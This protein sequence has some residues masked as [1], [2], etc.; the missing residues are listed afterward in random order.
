MPGIDAAGVAVVPS[1]ADGISSYSL[2][3]V[4]AHR[5]LENRER[6]FWFGLLLTGY[7]SFGFPFLHAG[8]ARAGCAQPC[9]C[10]MAGVA[11]F[12]FNLDPRT[13]RLVDADVQGIDGAARKF[14]VWTGC[15]AGEIFRNDADAFVAHTFVL[16][17]NPARCIYS[18]PPISNGLQRQGDRP[19]N[20]DSSHE[21]G[22][23]LFHRLVRK[24]MQK[25]E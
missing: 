3:F 18:P 20:R 23:L 14:Y 8:G 5:G 19:T 16:H 15:F 7:S 6:G 21:G 9:K 13:L 25:S 10:P 17:L 12:P 1:E 22:V 24:R 4:G 11:I 2:Y